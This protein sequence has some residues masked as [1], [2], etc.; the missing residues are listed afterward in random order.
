MFI[1]FLG[2]DILLLEKGLLFKYIAFAWGIPTMSITSVHNTPNGNIKVTRKSIEEFQKAQGVPSYES[3][4]SNKKN[5]ESQ[6]INSAANVSISQGAR[7][8]NLANQV[9]KDTPSVNEKRINELRERIQS[10]EYKVNAEKV[11]ES[12][13]RESLKDE[14]SKDSSLLLS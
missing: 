6:D 9:I 11:A 12:M 1:Y 3:Q 5:T 2:T 8:I 10:G 4:N 13:V 7:E 14:L